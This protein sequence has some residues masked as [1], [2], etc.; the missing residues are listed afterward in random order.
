MIPDDTPSALAHL[1]VQSRW[2]HKESGDDYVVVEIG[3]LEVAVPSCEHEELGIT[4]YTWVTCVRYT[5][6]KSAG[7]SFTRT[8]ERFIDRFEPLSDAPQG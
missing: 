5:S 7:G 8:L 4:T 3:L 2:R 1:T 6:L